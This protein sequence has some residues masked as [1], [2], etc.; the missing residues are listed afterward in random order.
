MNRINKNDSRKSERDLLFFREPKLFLKFQP[1]CSEVHK[2]TF[3]K[4]RGDKIVYELNFMRLRKRLA[5]FQLNDQRIV[6]QQI[7]R[8]RTDDLSV[9]L[10]A[11]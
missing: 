11:D 3:L 7:G 9:I 2:E 5:R 8:K 6:Y 1:L 4:S 10:D